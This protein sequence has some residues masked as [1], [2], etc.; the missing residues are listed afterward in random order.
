M[1]DCYCITFD[2]HNE[3]NGDSFVVHL[4]N[5]S[6]VFHCLTN[7]L[8]VHKLGQVNPPPVS[9]SGTVSWSASKAQNNNDKAVT[10]INTVNENRNFYTGRQFERAK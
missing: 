4:P 2:N 9:R 10:M 5:K 7:K 1:A 3:I 6:I 8:Y